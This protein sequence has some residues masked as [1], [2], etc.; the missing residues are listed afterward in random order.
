MILFLFGVLAASLRKFKDAE[1]ILIWTIFFF[2]LM[3]VQTVKVPRYMTPIL[4][5]MF[6]IAGYGFAKLLKDF[7][8]QKP[9]IY[10]LIILIV[11]AT[12]YASYA[13]AVILIPSAAQGFCGLKETGEFLTTV[14]QPDDVIMAASNTQIHWYSDIWVVSY[15]ADVNTFDAYVE[16]NSVDFLVVDVWERTAPQYIMNNGQ[17]WNP[18]FLNNEK[19]ELIW[20]YPISDSNYVSF[21]Y[22]VKE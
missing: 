12:T 8:K 1:L 3:S 6:I 16:E 9:L 11:G 5:T 19:Y 17:V 20:A 7:R 2:I 15:P 18:Y 22:K 13:E 14:A 10:A 4:P 21:V